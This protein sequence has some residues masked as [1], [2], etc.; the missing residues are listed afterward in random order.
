VLADQYVSTWLAS[1][2]NQ[3]RSPPT[4]RTLEFTSLRDLA[5]MDDMEGRIVDANS[6]NLAYRLRDDG[7]IV[8]A[9]SGNLAYRLRDDG[10]IVDA[11]SGN[12][13]YRLRT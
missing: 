6:G 12:L 1:P 7:R 11:N 3:V 5:I 9:N 2:Q 8:D 4:T 10:R 13:A